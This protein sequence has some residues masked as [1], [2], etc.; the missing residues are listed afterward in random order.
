MDYKL[1]IVN[2]RHFTSKE[3]K[4][5][6]TVDFILVTDDSCIDNDK[7]NGYITQTAFLD[8]NLVGKVEPLGAYTGHF[9]TEVK[10]LKSYLKLKSLKDKGGKT[11]S[12]A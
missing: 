10:G 1:L 6:N 7:F 11:I 12:L 2:T 4:V 8:T 9:D 5:C 3:G